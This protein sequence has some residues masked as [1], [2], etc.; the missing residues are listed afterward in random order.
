MEILIKTN[1]YQT[2]ITQE[3]KDSLHKEVYD[4]IM[5]YLGTV[6]FIQNLISPNREYIED[7]PVM[8]YE[9]H[10]GEIKEY[11]DGRKLI[12]ITNPHILNK[13]DLDFF[14]DRAIFYQKNGKY[15]TIPP[16]PNPNSDYAAFWKGEVRKW[17]YGVVAPSGDWIPGDLYYYWN[18]SRIWLTEADGNSKSN[19]RA[20][21]RTAFPRPW[22]GDYLFYHYM[23]Q[24]REMGMHGKLLKSRGVGFLEP[25]SSELHTPNGKIKVG[26]V[27]EGDYLID[28]RGNPT[29]VL[30]VYP[31]GKKNIYEVEFTDGRKVRCGLNH[32][33]NVEYK[34]KTI[35]LKT[36][37]LLERK[38]SNYIKN[39]KYTRYYYTL[40]QIE[41]VK[42]SNKD[43]EIDPYLLGI[44]IGDGNTCNGETKISTVDEE[45]IEII[46]TKLDLNKFEII[47]SKHSHYYTIKSLTNKNS[48]TRAIKAMGLNVKAECKYIPESYKY[49]SIEQRMEL[50][51]GLMDSDGCIANNGHINFTTSSPIL[52]SDF[53][54]LVRSL[55]IKCTF[56]ETNLYK[57][58][59]TFNKLQS[60]QISLMT[61]KDIFKLSR[62]K[63]RLQL[64]KQ[65]QDKVYVKKIHNLN[66]KEEST[67]FLVDN[68][69]HLYLTTDFVP[70][71]NSFKAA[72][73]SPRNL[74]VY[75]GS[76]NPNF[77]LASEKTFIEGD[78]GVWGKILDNL[79]W[80]ANNTPLPKIRSVDRRSG[81]P[82]V[83]LGYDD[84]Y[85]VR[86]GLQSSI[87]AISL[88]DN[89]DKARGV[90]GPLIHYEEDGL[91]PNLEKAW[92]VNREAVEDGGIAFG[93][94][95]AGGTGGVEGKSFAGSEKLFYTPRAFNVYP[96]P[97]V[98]D[99][100]T[101][102]KTECGFFW[103]AYLSRN[104]CYDMEIG[105]PDVIK[106]L[107]ELEQDRF[108]VKHNSSDPN[109]VTQAKAERPVTPQEAVM[110]TE[111]TVFP[112]ADLKDYLESIVVRKESFLS[113]HYVG[114]LIYNG[115]GEV[116]WKPNADLYPHRTYETTSD[117]RT[118][119]VEIF[120]MPKKNAEDVIPYG[121]YILGIDPIDADSG[122]SLFSVLVMDTFTDRIVAEYTGRP[123]KAVDAYET[124]LK[125]C[126]FYNGQANYEMNLKGLFSYFD[127][128]NA[129]HYLCDTP[130]I[131]RDMEFVKATN[132][133]GNKAK[134][135]RAAAQVNSWG[136]QLQADWMLTR[137]NS[138]DDEDKRFKMHTLRGLAY[139]EECIK[140]NADG[141]FDRVSAAGMLFILRE[142]RFKL[143]QHQK[144]NKDRA[145]KD[146]S[147][148]SFF[149]KN[150]GSNSYQ[151]MRGEM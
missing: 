128:R 55:G 82:E 81:V 118:G 32:L 39:G 9:D 143:I 44:L 58:K 93:Y 132:Q 57:R 90:R 34:G 129:L 148:D 74:Y 45:I 23:E 124:A 102:G 15:T 22:L 60:W 13:R 64:K 94:M 36:K 150:F 88:K 33:W 123:R 38:L 138:E 10:D 56:R 67:C 52:K 145:I 24:G 70:T 51:R 17:K 91:F 121:R 80:I 29:K 92:G 86:R 125:M 18:Y 16:N 104:K 105:E 130:Q 19:K 30:E 108:I 147:N 6:K 26:K 136:R 107:V 65:C 27:K 134:G 139:I 77:H 5:E 68:D 43:L 50:L 89:P 71:H 41:P 142:D 20:E 12:D 7:R 97:N 114:D 109:A 113:E 35:T 135:T 133:Y 141:N 116:E 48:I 110:R 62:K 126:I 112:V 103:G 14:R 63:E 84:N 61:K 119:A 4:N 149:N 131:L 137:V 2:P 101:D 49:S 87:T 31:Q 76:G 40:P 59:D 8:T 46:K 95:L 115:K 78:K 75:P 25:N 122:G 73:W 1:K 72:S 120:E 117:N 47:K 37:E 96:L 144:E 66:Y 85:G 106:A 98:F 99:K 151:A 54:E 79:D 146:L 11:E 21:R 3:L 127:S 42:Y 28:R 111:G 83:Q 53:I 69:E 100:N 140:W